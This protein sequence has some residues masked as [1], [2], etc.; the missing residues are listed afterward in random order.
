MSDT[1]SLQSDL[2]A[3][4][5]L[6][7]HDVDAVLASDIDALFSQ[8]SDDFVVI[9]SAGPI[10]RGRRANVEAVRNSLEQIRAFEPVE[11]VV[12]FAEITVVGHYAFEWGTFRGI[13]RPRAGG[14]AVS[15][16]G[17]LLRILQRQADGSWKMHRTMTT[18]DPAFQ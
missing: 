15:Y 3:I 14:E 10:V 16:K 4:T 8:W 11:F 5:A 7:Q 18:N 9:P 2:R 17:K 12:D 1:P 6:N 13:S